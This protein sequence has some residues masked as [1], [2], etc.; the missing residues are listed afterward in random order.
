ME[1]SAERRQLPRVERTHPLRE[2]SRA[3]HSFTELKSTESAQSAG[4]GLPPS[5]ASRRHSRGSH[6]GGAET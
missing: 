6:L 5:L 1:G 2:H 4:A 3:T